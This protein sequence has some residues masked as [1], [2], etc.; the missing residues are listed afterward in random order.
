MHPPLRALQASAL[1]VACLTSCGDTSRST[2]PSGPPSLSA[3]RFV[4]F[5]AFIMGGDPSN[6]LALQAGFDP[7]ITA[8]DIC[9][10]PEGLNLHGEGFLLFTPPGG[11]VLNS[12]AR[13]AAMV[14]YAFG[15]GP[16]GDPCQ[17]EGAP[18]VGTGTG[19]FSYHVTD[20]GPGALVIHVTAQGTI[21]LTAGGQARLHATARIVVLPDDTLL[22]D[23]ERVR[24][25]PL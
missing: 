9:A 22:L 6:P 3:E 20:A 10:N 19:K 18:I 2:D 14:V 24:L 16:V 12:S 4:H 8:D 7:G 17:L 11:S 15:G 25:T 21:D 5:D 1:A 23:V 13:D